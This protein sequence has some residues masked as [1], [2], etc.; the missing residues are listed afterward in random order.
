DIQQAKN[1]LQLTR[2]QVLSRHAEE[3]RG[4]D[5]EQAEIEMLNLLAGSFTRKFKRQVTPP[6]APAITV[7]TKPEPPAVPT[8]V[9]PHPQAHAHHGKRAGKP[10]HHRDRH[11]SDE[12]KY[13]QT[14]FD[15]F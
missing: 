14:N 7:E 8:A 3:L 4:L 1:Q 10:G 2:E 15:V 6:P 11:Y 9:K 5:A 12:R 13:A